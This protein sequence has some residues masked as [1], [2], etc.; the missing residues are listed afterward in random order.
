MVTG[1]PA[2]TGPTTRPVPRL[3]GTCGGPVFTG[4]IERFGSRHHVTASSHTRALVRGM[5]PRLLTAVERDL[6]TMLGPEFAPSGEHGG[7]VLDLVRVGT[8]VVC[9]CAETDRP[10]GTEAL[11]PFAESA[12]LHAANGLPSQMLRLGV[13]TSY[14]GVLRTAL[15]DAAHRDRTALMPVVSWGARLGPLI[16]QTEMTAFL[17][18]HRLSG[19]GRR[20]RQETVRALL[21]GVR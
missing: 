6:A 2:R 20:W 1:S 10:P 15:V 16:E 18:W 19:H 8:D 11:R 3:V 17:D 9:A 7:R 14:T 4:P 5:L 21:S 13:I 12:R